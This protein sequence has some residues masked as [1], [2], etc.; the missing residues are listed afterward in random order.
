MNVT[1]QKR[2]KKPYHFKIQIII[3]EAEKLKM[4]LSRLSVLE[5]QTNLQLMNVN[6]R[7]GSSTFGFRAA[8]RRSDVKEK[9][10][11]QTRGQSTEQL[12]ASAVLEKSKQ[13]L[14]YLQRLN[15]R[16]VYRPRRPRVETIRREQR[17]RG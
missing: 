15:G 8:S 1:A 12:K 9:V 11:L 13:L 14:L 17:Y 16:P 6:K 7:Q 3:S 10:G 4:V 5:S 2:K